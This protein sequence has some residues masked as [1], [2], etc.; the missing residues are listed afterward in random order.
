LDHTPENVQSHKLT[1]YSSNEIEEIIANSRP[2]EN[3]DLS[4]RYNEELKEEANN[5]EDMSQYMMVA[6]AKLDQKAFSKLNEDELLD[7]V[8][9]LGRLAG[10]C[11]ILGELELAQNF[12]ERSLGLVEEYSLGEKLHLVQ[13][14]RW[15]DILRYK[16][17][18]DV[19]E[20]IFFDILSTCRENPLLNILED[21]CLQHLG[22][23][24]FDRADFAEALEFF[25]EALS[26]RLKKQDTQLIDSS[27]YAY[28]LTTKRLHEQR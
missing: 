27:K 20:D 19:A 25:Q 8:T 28:E 2:I 21:F 22:K 5:P 17:K 14:L 9:T 6:L 13:S 1:H 18:L 12:I 4:Y 7:W 15:A 26:I 10:Y 24:F 3:F 11:K 16:G 23:V